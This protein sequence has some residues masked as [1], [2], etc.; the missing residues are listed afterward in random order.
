MT[1]DV[2][3]VHPGFRHLLEPG[4]QC[5]L[6]HVH[7]AGTREHDTARRHQNGG[8]L[9]WDPPIILVEEAA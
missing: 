3:R 7:G 4:A 5:E 2:A 8:L 1:L 9:W 6:E